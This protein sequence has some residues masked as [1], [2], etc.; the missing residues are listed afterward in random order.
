MSVS[1]KIDFN[2]VSKL[3]NASGVASSASLYKDENFWKR[4]SYML[5]VASIFIIS[6]WNKFK[7]QDFNSSEDDFDKYSLKKN[8][9][10]DSLLY[11]EKYSHIY[12][13]SFIIFKKVSIIL[14]FS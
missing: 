6:S 5:L 2:K 1:P 4:N 13:L 3:N 9:Y 8:I 14:I 7:I 10:I 11:D 12:L